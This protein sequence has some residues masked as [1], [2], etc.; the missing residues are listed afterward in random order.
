MNRI[1]WWAGLALALCLPALAHSAS[2]VTITADPGDTSGVAA[3]TSA[4]GTMTVSA[5]A[6]GGVSVEF[7]PSAPPLPPIFFDF[8]PAQGAPFATGRYEIPQRFPDASAQRPA[9]EVY[10]LTRCGVIAGRFIVRELG[11]A[12]DGSVSS[13]AIDFEEYCDGNT[14]G[15]HGAVRFNSSLPYAAEVLPTSVTTD[16]AGAP[17]TLSVSATTPTCAFLDTEFRD[18]GAT[19]G[20]A[21][22]PYGVF[23]FRAVG[24]DPQVS[25]TTFTLDFVQPP[26]GNVVLWKYGGTP[27]N[28]SAHWYT[29]PIT[30][31]A[32][33]ISFTIADGGLGDDDLTVNGVIQS[34]GAITVGGVVQDMWWGGPAENGWGLSIEQHGASLFNVLYVYDNAGNPTWLAMAGGSWAAPF[35]SYTAP[36]IR[37]RGSPYYAFDVTLVNSGP[38]V[39]T[40]TITFTDLDHAR[41]DYTIDGVAGTKQI[42]RQLYGP[43]TSAAAGPYADMFWGGEG[44][45][46]WG[47][48]VEQQFAS[49][50]SVWFTYDAN[51]APTWF[52]MPAGAWTDDSFS[53]SAGRLYKTM[54]SA[55]LGNAYDPSRLRVSDVGSYSIHFDAPTS[56]FE[57]SAEG[58]HGS[59]VLI[60]QP[61]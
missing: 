24:C 23:A 17:V 16:T 33:Q 59:M 34:Y 22:V 53:T 43:S 6:R 48:A 4:V 21:Q 29:I 49:L 50:F 35:T 27:D 30:V 7:Q 42:E 46:G 18:A 3:M 39:G 14:A 26:A 12:A 58:H 55:W 54:G 61:F 2:F 44:Q 28:I 5:N 37:P 25:T 19:N 32:N 60:P 13:L 51:G 45:K 38:P 47:I 40:A 11:L 20:M 15:I 56:T 10:E 41:L 31:N 57:Y 36:L 52:A 1:A 9:M 8:G